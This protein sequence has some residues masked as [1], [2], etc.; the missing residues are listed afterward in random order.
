MLVVSL[1]AGAIGGVDVG[2]G[3]VSDAGDDGTEPEAEDG[4]AALVGEKNR[5]C[6]PGLPAQST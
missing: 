6:L 2:V 3:T 5:I 1:D 4:G